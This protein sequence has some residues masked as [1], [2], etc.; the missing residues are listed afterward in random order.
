MFITRRTFEFPFHKLRGQTKRRQHALLLILTIMIMASIDGPARA[1]EIPK[2]ILQK[3]T[4]Y[5]TEYYEL[6]T[7]LDLEKAREAA[8]RLDRMAA[9][10][11]SRT[12][13]IQGNEPKRMGCYL[14]RD[15]RDFDAVSG[16][17]LAKAGGRFSSELGLL[18]KFTA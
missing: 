14:F 12:K 10:Y 13:F 3:L 2:S 6:Y 11:S 4:H 15:G 5:D 9:E 18:G 16:P 1:L 7:D 8:I 17:S